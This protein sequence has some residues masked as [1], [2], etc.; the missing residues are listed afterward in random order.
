MSCSTSQHHQ[1]PTHTLYTPA[2]ASE[3][4]GA[5]P[6]GTVPVISI[7]TPPSKRG[8][9]SL[10]VTSMPGGRGARLS[11]PRAAMRRYRRGASAVWM[12]GNHHE[13]FGKGII[14]CGWQGIIMG[15]LVRSCMYLSSSHVFP[16]ER[17]TMYSTLMH[18]HDHS[19]PTWHHRLVIQRLILQHTCAKSLSQLL[20]W[21]QALDI[22]VCELWCM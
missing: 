15:G 10:G 16:C 22:N 12:S 20:T 4:N 7:T 21:V 2:Y 14:M 19:C 13:G 8:Q 1:A 3:N 5:L 9:V 17:D 11:S 18:A 6:P